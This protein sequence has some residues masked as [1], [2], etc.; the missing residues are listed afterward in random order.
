[1][2][3]KETKYFVFGFMGF[4]QEIDSHIKMKVIFALAD[5]KKTKLAWYL[6]LQNLL[7]KTWQNAFDLADLG[8]RKLDR[9]NLFG[10]M[11]PSRPLDVW[12]DRQHGHFDIEKL[13]PR[14]PSASGTRAT[15]DVAD[16]VE[17]R[18][19]CQIVCDVQPYNVRLDF[20]LAT[21]SPRIGPD[22]SRKEG[23]VY[24]LGVEKFDALSLIRG[25]RGSSALSRGIDPYSP[26]F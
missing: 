19:T 3:V 17:G 18:T 11:A 1:M 16:I 2:A 20:D 8:E 9:S 25:I 22:I 15:I 13:G 6:F 21:E 10:S 26:V 24:L 7:V 23:R 5:E 4:E 14:L 12:P